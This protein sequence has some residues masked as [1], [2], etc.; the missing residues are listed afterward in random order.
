MTTRDPDEDFWA[1]AEAFYA[2]HPV[3]E[4]ARELAERVLWDATLL[5]GLEG[6]HGGK[7]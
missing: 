2:A 6:E 4:D 1:N 3:A 5:D 7:R